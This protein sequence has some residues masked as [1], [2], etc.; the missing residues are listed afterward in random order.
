MEAQILS[1]Y[2]KYFTS[3]TKDKKQNKNNNN[4]EMRWHSSALLFCVKSEEAI[5]DP[6]DEATAQAVIGREQMF[7]RKLA[8]NNHSSSDRN[9]QEK[10]KRHTMIVIQWKEDP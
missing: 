7:E 6:W 3:D 5:G 1:L 9:Q 10:H 8:F 2:K 4:Y